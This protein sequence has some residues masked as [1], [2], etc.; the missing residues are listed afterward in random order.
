MTEHR[1][2][3]RGWSFAFNRR[4]RSLGLCHFEAKRIELSALFV[5]GNNEPA[6]RDTLLHEIAH[7][8]AGRRAGH[9][10]RWAAVCQ[11]LGAT[12]TRTCSTAVMPTGLYQAKCDGCGLNHNRHRRPMRAR[13]YYCRACGPDR[14]KLRFIKRDPSM[15]V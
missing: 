13:T 1:L 12:P 3:Q 11:C 8:L 7:A 4:K 2:I 15:R 9:G 10:S 14:G 6:V 5:T